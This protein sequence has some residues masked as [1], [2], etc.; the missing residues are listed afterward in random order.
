MKKLIIY[1]IFCLFLSTNLFS[2][3]FDGGI[4]GGISLAQI[5][6]DQLS[7]FDNIGLTGG[8]FVR[9]NL[10]EYLKAQLEL[11]Y[12]KKGAARWG[13]NLNPSV[14][15]VSLHYV[16]MPVLAQLS[17]K[18][19]FLP[20][21]GL[22]VGKMM[23]AK[24]VDYAGSLPHDPKEKFSGWDFNFLIGASFFF[25]DKLGANVRWGYSI[26]PAYEAN[27]GIYRGRISEMLG[28]KDGYYNNYLNMAVYYMIDFVR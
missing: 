5:D 13:D 10:N 17:I 1:F 23:G 15:M 14:Y 18:E 16:D 24:Y 8:L 19:K 27:T 26:I 21:I 7:G 3:R 9:T 25:T 12:N 4:L 11:K 6:G 2:Q 28:L 22:S 20:E